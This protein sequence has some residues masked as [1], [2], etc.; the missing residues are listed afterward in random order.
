MAIWQTQ[1]DFPSE[2]A[3]TREAVSYLD[4]EIG[5]SA[6]F[7][8]FDHYFTKTPDGEQVT[9]A[10][11]KE[12]G[13]RRVS[14]LASAK[15]KAK[16]KTVA[17]MRNLVK[18]HIGLWVAIGLASYYGADSVETYRQRPSGPSS[19]RK[20]PDSWHPDLNW[21]TAYTPHRLVRTGN[22]PAKERATH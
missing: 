3:R 14:Q 4:R 18:Q 5:K 11:L 10:A 9:L 17:A 8:I 15:A 21:V 13:L 19:T 16:G 22:P 7:R 12:I 20:V 6:L 2:T 1:K